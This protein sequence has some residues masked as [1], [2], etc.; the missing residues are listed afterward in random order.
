MIPVTSLSVLNLE[1]EKRLKD[2]YPTPRSDSFTL[3]QSTVI[4]KC[5]TRNNYRDRMHELLYVEELARYEQVKFY[6]IYVYFKL[7][8]LGFSDCEV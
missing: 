8:I 2:N 4:E 3:T 6:F 7:F 1:E 5:L